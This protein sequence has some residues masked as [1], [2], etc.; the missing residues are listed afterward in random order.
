LKETQ[1]AWLVECEKL[2]HKPHR[3]RVLLDKSLTVVGERWFVRRF[4]PRRALATSLRWISLGALSPTTWRLTRPQKTLSVPLQAERAFGGQ[5]RIGFNDKAAKRLAKRHRLKA[6]PWARA[7]PYT[8]RAE[9]PANPVG[10][11]WARH[12]YLKAKRF[13]RIPA[14]QIEHPGRPVT[15]GHF[16]KSH[17]GKLRDKTAASLVAGL[18]THTKRHPERSRLAGDP[19]EDWCEAKTKLPEDFAF[20]LWNA[21]WPDQQT[22]H[23]Q[24]NESIELV[25]LCDPNAQGV[26]YDRQGNTVLRLTL[27]GDDCFALLQY[28]NGHIHEHPLVIDTLIVEPET[29]TLCLVWR[30]RLEQDSANPLRTIETRMRAFAAREPL[31]ATLE[32][33][34]RLAP[35]GLTP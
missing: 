18:G 25:N 15:I 23:L 35:Q 9:L 27:P 7:T 26:R 20:A 17:A 1:Q 30:A 14:P 8:A 21:A 28:N 6:R 31:H 11:G 33:L 13:R 2:Q 32:T 34:L 5:C 10:R 16:T 19:G 22:R 3:V 4:W 24:G 12:W 29:R